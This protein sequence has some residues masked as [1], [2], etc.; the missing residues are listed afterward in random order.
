M[1]KKLLSGFSTWV[2]CSLHKYRDLCNIG[3]QISAYDP[4]LRQTQLSLHFYKHLYKGLSNTYFGN[5][6]LTQ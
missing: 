5:A 3:R 1:Q 4:H 2:G 6:K